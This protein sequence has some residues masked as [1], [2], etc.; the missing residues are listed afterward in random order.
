MARQRVFTD[1]NVRDPVIAVEL[2][3]A[4]KKAYEEAR[5]ENILLNPYVELTL[6]LI[7][8]DGEKAWGYYFADYKRHTIFWFEDHESMDLM[9]NIRGVHHKTHVSKFFSWNAFLLRS[10]TRVVHRVWIRITV[11]VRMISRST[12]LSPIDQ[13]TWAHTLLQFYLPPLFTYR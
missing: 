13:I 12:H 11:L 2:G 3:E 5:K 9:N 10:N 1:V 7:E 6:E 8:L 4:V